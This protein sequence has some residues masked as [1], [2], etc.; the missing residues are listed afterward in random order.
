[1]KTLNHHIR[2]AFLP[3]S[4]FYGVEL[5]THSDKSLA[6][7]SCWLW[8]YTLNYPRF[9]VASKNAEFPFSTATSR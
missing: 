9:V 3:K 1:M 4:P 5:K 6:M 8:L 2:K 7:G